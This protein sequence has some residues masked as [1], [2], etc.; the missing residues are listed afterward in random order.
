MLKVNK[1]VTS[2]LPQSTPSP[3]LPYFIFLCGPYDRTHGIVHSSFDYPRMLAPQ[4]QDF[5]ISITALSPVLKTAPGTCLVLDK[6]LLN[7]WMSLWQRVIR[8][9]IAERTSVNWQTGLQKVIQINHWI[10]NNIKAKTNHLKIIR[11]EKLNPNFMLLSWG[12][13]GG[14]TKSESQNPEVIENNCISSI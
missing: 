12:W 14:E 5:C 11:L 13:A 2:P 1:K 4:G 3:S 9:F 10:I 8:L 7:K 6:Y